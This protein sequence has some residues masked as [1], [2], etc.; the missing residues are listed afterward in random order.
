MITHDP[1]PSNSAVTRNLERGAGG[2][3]VSRRYSADICAD[4]PSLDL[5]NRLPVQNTESAAER[6]GDTS[7]GA[8]RLVEG[9]RELLL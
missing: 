8:W 5:Q 9:S 7:G 1:Q 6:S 4:R 2:A 3:G